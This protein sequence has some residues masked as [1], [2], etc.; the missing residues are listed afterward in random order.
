MSKT[1]A[2]DQLERRVLVHFGELSLKGQNRPNYVQRLR[3]NVQQRLQAEGF[4][5]PV[6][7][8][9]DRL[10]VEAGVMP[11]GDMQRLL[12][13]LDEVPGISWY[14]PA[15]W[16]DRAQMGLETGMLELDLLDQAVQELAAPAWREGA[17]FAIR[18]KRGNK[19]FPMRS[20]DLE[21]HLGGV[22]LKNTPWSQVSL[23]E[24][25]FRILLDVV[26]H[27]AYL[28]TERRKGMGGLPLG[29][30]GRVLTLL[31]GGFD[32]PVAAWLMAKRGCEVDFIHFTANHMQQKQAESYKVARIVQR[33]SRV[34]GRT[35]L[36]LVPYTH[37][38]LALMEQQ[39]PY[40]LILFRRF[41]ARCAQRLAADWGAQVLVTGDNLGQVASQTMENMVSMTRSVDM[42]VLRPLLTYEKE[43]IIDLSRRLELFETCKEPYKDC[44]ALISHSPK[45]RSRHDKLE[46]IETRCFE[47]YDSL[48]ENSLAEAT[49]LR[50]RYGR[51]EDS[52]E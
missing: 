40:D 47:D 50:Y 49:T 3:T 7:S 23:T 1:P 11:E 38:D 41:M 30:T 13:C 5:V 2:L 10:F 22:V 4:E 12:A 32:S 25:D 42:P 20:I 34:L 16:I 37:F 14:T 46:A 18:V 31:S 29:M 24:P 52:G 39:V 43:E 21:R 36:H 45:T 26:N 9:Y 51:L 33:L 6:R 15:W 28:Y 44:C 8:A 35:R 17:R 27:G 48:I 19:G